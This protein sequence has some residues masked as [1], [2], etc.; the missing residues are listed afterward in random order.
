MN[1]GMQCAGKDQAK[2]TLI[3]ASSARNLAIA[4]TAVRRIPIRSPTA[5]FAKLKAIDLAAAQSSSKNSFANFAKNLATIKMIVT[6][7]K[8]FWLKR[9]IKGSISK[10][11][12]QSTTTL[13]CL[14]LGTTLKLHSMPKS[15][16]LSVKP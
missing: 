6:N 10:P 1:K 9:K 11:K 12:R 5:N 3:S 14:M 13:T 2:K 4:G 15:W 16:K 8:I 7:S